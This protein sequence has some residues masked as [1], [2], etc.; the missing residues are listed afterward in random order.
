MTAKQL[1]FPASKWKLTP[2]SLVVIQL[3]KSLPANLGFVLFVDNFFTNARLFKALRMIGIG[4]CGTAKVGSGYPTELVAIR[5]AATKKKDWGKMGLM[6]VRSDK[7]TNIDDG[8]VFCMAWVDLNTVQYMTTTHTIDEMKTVVY[9]D[10]KR[11]NGIPKSA[12]CD[13]KIPFPAPIIEYN[14]HMGGS[15]GNAQQRSYYSS[16]CPDSRYWWPLFTFL[17]DA[18]VLN[19]FKLWGRLYPDSKLTHSEFQH[20]IA[21]VLMTNGATRKHSIN[22]SISEKKPVDKSTSCEWEHTGKKSYC[23]PCREEEVRL[24]KRRALEEISENATKKRRTPQT[25]WQ[26]KSCGPCCKKE[27][28]WRALHS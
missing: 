3:C 7:K 6:T 23:R 25:R 5:A 22:L 2:S 17:L 26:C 19:S 16:Q 8:D 14:R 15:D 11:R 20:Q 12:I 27:D 1:G 9:K 4:A 10:A 21:E 28:C 18:A 13:E 24:R